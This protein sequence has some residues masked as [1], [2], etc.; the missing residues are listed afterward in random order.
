MTP[1]DIIFALFALL[2]HAAICV[3][4]LN[5]SHSWGVARVL[6]K[7][8][9]L[10]AFVCLPL[11]PAA[12][13]WP[14]LNGSTP[15]V[16]RI[17]SGGAGWWLA[18]LIPC[19]IAASVV[20]VRWVRREWL[21]SAPVLLQSNHTLVV[22]IAKQ[23]G[24]RPVNGFLWRTLT[25]LPGNQ[26]LIAHFHEKTLELP[27][28]DRALDGMT[29]LHLSDFHFTG[30]IDKSLFREIARLAMR[31]T[32]DLIALTGDFVDNAECI[33]WIPDVFSPLSARHGVYFVLG[34]H[35]PR[36]GQVPRLRRALTD[37]GFVDLAG[38]WMNLEINGCPVVIAGNEMPWIAPA[39][40]M[41]DCP[42]EIA[43]RRPLRF[44]VA[45]TPD[46]LPWARRHDF[47]LMLAGHTH[48]GQ[49]CL[50]VIGPIFC[51]SRHGLEYAAG[52]FHEPPTV[53]HV[54][55]GISGETPSRWNCP[56][57]VALLTLQAAGGA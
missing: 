23:L 27:R 26:D 16:L 11:V 22:D 55:R 14:V 20:I 29:I 40:D 8:V 39:P 13:L 4:A 35:D 9:T 15:A 52:V 48:G 50:P 43:S 21:R 12:A 19:W 45:H 28:L 7:M 49:V 2:G 17:S 24:H 18:Y 38:R 41:G 6:V 47:D 37:M 32:P 44:L 10:L 53:M 54:S 25:R 51:P 57:E 46:Q 5:R 42:S 31:T 56:P 30:R 1:L 34:N 33:E 36:M 3:G